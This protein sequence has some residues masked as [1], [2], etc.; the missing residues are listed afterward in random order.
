MK[1][2]REGKRFIIASLLIAFAA[3]N[4]GNNLVYLILSLMLSFIFL[5]ALLL[6]INLSR[7]SLKV[8][9]NT[10][11]FAGDT[12]SSRIMIH[13]DKRLLPGYSVSVRSPVAI[14]PVYFPFIPA[15]STA[16]G[17][18]K[19]RFKRR[20]LYRFED[21]SAT[22]GFP[23]ILFSR[24]GSIHTRGEL[25]VYPELRDV[26]D[27][28][29]EAFGS[30][31]EGAARLTGAGEDIYSMR[32]YRYGD[33][34]RR[35][36]W[37]AS[38]KAAG[39]LV[40]E[41][42]EYSLKKATILIDNLAAGGNAIDYP[43]KGEGAS[44]DE[45]FEVV[46]SL[47]GSLARLFLERGYFVKVLSCRKVIP[48]GRGDEHFFKIL[49]ILAIM[50]EEEGWD[51]P[52]SSEKEGVFISVLRSRQTALSRYSSMSDIVIYADTL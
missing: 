6:R 12:A 49:D 10:P 11:V 24:R 40:K 3:L 4:T 29:E 1:T 42:A 38:A 30:G 33:D 50:K 48:F 8:G 51:S 47:S 34:R 21:F 45:Q 19:L 31:I 37:K 52:V 44:L 25:L 20:G 17:D 7:L 43:V 15:G 9:V 46:V 32:E 27:F 22:S 23:F 28:V 39:L 26:D 16:T 41:Y 35:I 2:T 18:L 14:S 13:N 36:H 5:S